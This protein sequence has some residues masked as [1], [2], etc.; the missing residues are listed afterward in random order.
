MQH[1]LAGKTSLIIYVSAGNPYHKT[2]V[3]MF[4]CSMA[5]YYIVF[6][7]RDNT[8]FIR[9]V[10]RLSLSMKTT[11]MCPRLV[12]LFTRCKVNCN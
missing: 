5:I 8:A 1:K 11:F 9:I 10:H 12:V 4:K 6:C 2:N 3:D 7:L